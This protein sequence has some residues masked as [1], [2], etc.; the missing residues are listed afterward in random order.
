MEHD[1]ILDDSQ[2]ET[3]SALFPAAALVDAVETFENPSEMFR[4]DPDAVVREAQR[5]AT[6]GFAGQFDEY[7]A[8]AGVGYGIVGQVAED[9]QQQLLVPVQGHLPVEEVAVDTHAVER[10]PQG[11]FGSHFADYVAQVD[12]AA[13]DN[14]ASLIHSGQR[15]DILKQLQQPFALGIAFLDKR[16]QLVVRQVGIVDDRLQI[17]L[18]GAYRSLEFVIDV[19]GQLPLDDRLLLLF[20]QDLFVFAAQVVLGPLQLAV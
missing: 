20:A 10:R 11:H 18:Y 4:F 14:L 8:A 9:R 12:L 7:V 17:P 15:R 13:L 5:I 16:A 2:S 6:V 1:G 3:G 19:V